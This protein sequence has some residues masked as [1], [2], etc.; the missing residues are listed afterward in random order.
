MRMVVMPA[1]GAAIANGFLRIST[2]ITGIVHR[3]YDLNT[4]AYADCG[5]FSMGDAGDIHHQKCHDHN[6]GREFFHDH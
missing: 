5:A 3:F 6:K 2:L 4:I 1:G